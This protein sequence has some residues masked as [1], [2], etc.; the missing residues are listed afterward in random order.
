MAGLAVSCGCAADTSRDYVAFDRSHGLTVDIPPPRDGE[1]EESRARRGAE[2]SLRITQGLT[3]DEAIEIALDANPSL[4]AAGEV[5]NAAKANI[6]QQSLFTNPVLT[7]GSDS[8]PTSGARNTPYAGAT[9]PSLAYTPFNGGLFND[10]LNGVFVDRPRAFD[11]RYARNYVNVQKDFDVSGKRVARVD[12]AIE[13]ERQTEAQYASS[14]LQVKAQVRAAYATVLI[15]ERNHELSKEALEMA[16]K[17]LEIVSLRA[18][19]GNALPGDG[20]RAEGDAARARSDLAQGERDLER[21]KRAL[22]TLLAQPDVALGP[23]RDELPLS[24]LAADLDAST[25]VSEALERNP[26]VIAAKRAVRAADANLRLQKRSAIPDVTVGAQ[27]G[28]DYAD[29][30]SV[31]FDQSWWLSFSVGIP[32]PIFDQNRAQ[33]AQAIANVHQAEALERAVEIATSQQVRDDVLVARASAARIEAFQKEILPRAREAVSLAETGYEGGK[34]LYTDVITAR[35]NFNQ[36]RMDY[37]SELMN[38]EATVA[39][40]ERLLARPLSRRSP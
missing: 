13:S 23:L 18:A 24:I 28:L 27:V 22:A 1:T 17:N 20:V 33:V 29:P 40:L 19:G 8:L 14:A 6:W 5:V 39:D 2:Q 21:A 25:L 12:A 7:L 15:T 35:Q 30:A 34:I 3:L 37:V 9:G 4:V 31:Q 11:F 26:D 32:V 16:Q 10:P 38:H 36:Q